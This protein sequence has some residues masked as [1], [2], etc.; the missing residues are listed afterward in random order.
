[1]P[2]LQGL[3]DCIFGAGRQGAALLTCRVD[4]RQK[5]NLQA[6]A[7]GA[8]YPDQMGHQ[9]VVADKGRDPAGLAIRVEIRQRDGLY[10]AAG[11]DGNLEQSW[12]K[13]QDLPPV[14]RRSFGKNE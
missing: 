9:G 7:S 1:M 6:D 3:P 2:F 5:P 4:R 14:G 10:R 13:S 11:C 8:Q 12:V